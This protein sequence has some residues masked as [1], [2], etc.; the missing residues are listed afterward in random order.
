M[1]LITFDCETYYSSEYSL[2]KMSTEDYVNDPRFELMLVGLKINDE[3]PQW[4]SGTIAQI[5]AWLDEVGFWDACVIAHNMFFDGLILAVHFG[6]L[7]KKM[8]CTLKMAQAMLKP[9][10][11]SIS[12]DSCLKSLPLGIQKGDEVHN[13]LG[14]TR[15]SLSKAELH[16]YAQYCMDDCEGEFRLFKYLAPLFP[17]EEFDVIDLT[18][19]MYLE[20]TF[21]LDPHLLAENLAAAQAKKQEQLSSI[22]AYINPKQ[23]TSNPQ[24]A[25]LLQSFGIEPPRKVSPTTGLMTWAFSKNDTGWKELEEEYADDPLISSL[26]TARLGSKSTLEESRSQKLLDIALKY[27]L[28]RVPLRYYAAHTGRYGGME[29]L[30]AQNLPGVTKSKMR[31]AIKA[32]KGH[33]VLA[34][35]L[36]QIEARITAWLAKQTQ[37]VTAFRNGDDVYSQFASKIFHCEVVK[38]RSPE[39]KRKRFVGKTC[40]L[41][42][43]FGMGAT[44]LRSTL[45]KDGL[46]F[47]DVECKHMV[48]LY[49]ET[50]SR[51]AQLWR[52][53]DVVLPIMQ[54]GKYRMGPCLIA[55]SA[56]VLP[57][58]MTLRYTDL[59]YYNPVREKTGT[60]KLL[61]EYA[62]YGYTFGGEFRT[63]WGGKMTENV[64]QALAQ[65]IIKK[66]MLA[67]HKT[68][69]LRPAL[70]QHDELDYIVP[71]ID[72]EAISES[73]REIMIVP[74]DWAPD[75]P[76]DV[77]IN[78]GP[79]LGH[80]K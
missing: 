78:Y 42:L 79:S 16:R 41:G 37:L 28:F 36:A 20:P 66:N 57:N 38:D 13:M 64:V 27:K 67:I 70:Q 61:D 10:M 39:D 48:N 24:F 59:K 65:I 68:L 1:K 71:A 63:L 58:R 73:I 29:G 60:N 31:F 8:L 22:P 77:E 52:D 53:F 4:R 2:T 49:R 34:A 45:R 55:G 43:G 9:A 7:P 12:L 40:I 32:P 50:Y 19:R 54:T 17:R 11:R 23:L 14:R 47:S 21:V 56:I 18:L 6:R 44:K 15:A 46:K 33:V 5:R 35:D 62:G 30:N 69:G 76:L 80:C 74:P 26:M 75:L 25:A 3:P 51:I 72:A